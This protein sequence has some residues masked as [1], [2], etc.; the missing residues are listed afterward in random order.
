MRICKRDQAKLDAQNFKKLMYT[1]GKI[2]EEVEKVNK[3][4]GKLNL[5]KPF[6]VEREVY[7]IMPASLNDDEASQEAVEKN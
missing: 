1:W 7:A 2:D 6:V 3:M 5:K 4:R